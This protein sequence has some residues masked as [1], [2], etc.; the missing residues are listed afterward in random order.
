M[1]LLFIVLNINRLSE[2]EREKIQAIDLEPDAVRRD[3]KKVRIKALLVLAFKGYAY[4]STLR[5][6]IKLLRSKPMVLKKDK[7]S[8]ESQGTE[9]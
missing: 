9:V 6:L 2:K 8:V 3:K 4:S 7:R 1:P 5:K